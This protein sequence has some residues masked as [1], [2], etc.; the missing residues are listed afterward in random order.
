[1]KT[2]MLCLKLYSYSCVR[3]SLWSIFY[4]LC[5]TGI[6]LSGACYFGISV[7]LPLARKIE[8]AN[9]GKVK[10]IVMK[11]GGSELF[12]SVKDEIMCVT[13]DCLTRE[14][15][16]SSWPPARAATSISQDVSASNLYYI[17]TSGSTGI[18]KLVP[19][20]Q[21][22]FTLFFN[23]VNEQAWKPK[24]NTQSQAV[25]M[26]WA[27]VSF[28]VHIMEIFC[29]L[30]TGS[31][32]VLCPRSDILD[33]MKTISLISKQKIS[34][35]VMVPAM[36][37]TLMTVANDEGR[38]NDLQTLTNLII[39]A[40]VFCTDVLPKMQSNLS[41]NL[42]IM[43]M[44]GPAECSI[45]STMWD[46]ENNTKYSS[47]GEIPI[48]RPLQNYACAV[49]DAWQRP[50]PVNE[51]GE[52][53][54]GGAGVFAGYL[55]RADLT[56]KALLNL[57]HVHVGL[58]R[59]YR[60]GDLVRLLASGA[61]LFVGRADSQVKIRGQRLELG[62]IESSLMLHP[63]VL[64]AAV[65][66][67]RRDT[68]NCISFLAAYV[69]L[70]NTTPGSRSSSFR[71]E[72]KDHVSAALPNY[73]VPTAWTVMPEL[74]MNQ[75]GK[76]DRKLLPK[77]KLERLEE[78]SSQIIAASCDGEQE[79]LDM[80]KA[81]LGTAE[82][83]VL[84]DFYSVGFNS[85]LSARFL[86][87]L[88]SLHPE[89]LKF[90]WTA[91]FS[92]TT[93][94]NVWIALQKFRKESNVASLLSGEQCASEP[95]LQ[96]WQCDAALGLQLHCQEDDFHAAEIPSLGLVRPHA[97]KIF[98]TGA[99]GFIGVFLLQKLLACNDIEIIG[100]IRSTTIPEVCS[101]TARTISK[102]VT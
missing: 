47:N 3:L 32:L 27:S 48:G 58:R 1:M 41:P 101:Y 68:S 100:L 2:K 6:V 80:I 88:K 96:P 72:L 84:D 44:Y 29:A 40:D 30:L 20:S 62:E 19:I 57:E 77:P 36:A 71:S 65:I 91:F 31:K 85:L 79:I 89:Y 14:V 46:I 42:R 60:T 8:M 34:H 95:V 23:S 78:S 50:V 49:L 25:V 10:L 74:P 76:I 87:A 51:V 61:L 83:S 56:A 15:S 43:N 7:E 11:E 38:W 22:N 94:R 33:P 39:G 86:Y 59:A 4:F 5:P 70:R 13:M 28:D 97:E 67:R 73:M 75:N 99:T 82:L 12:N 9:I 66:K 93:V 45:V 92:A 52:L 81:L 69:A 53:Y 37:R 17:S 21:L 98:L 90:S 16:T 55:G 18:P 26:Q 24:L 64:R 63:N 54:I 102:C 35:I